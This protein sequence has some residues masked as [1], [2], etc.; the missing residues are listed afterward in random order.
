MWNPSALSG[1][2]LSL[3][4]ASVMSLFIGGGPSAIFWRIPFIIVNAVNCQIVSIPVR[5]CPIVKRLKIV[6]PFVANGNPPIPIVFIVFV[7]LV[8]TPIFHARPY[9]IQPCIRQPSPSIGDSEAPA[10]LRSSILQSIRSNY[11][12]F[13]AVTAAFPSRSSVACVFGTLQ[14]RKFSEFFPNEVIW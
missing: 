5:H 3:W 6:S 9:T 7:I 1:R 8:V 11:D 2:F 12:R 14:N 13:P 4:R 10:A